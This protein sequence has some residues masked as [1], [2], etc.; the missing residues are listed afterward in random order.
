M[1]QGR[2]Q[3][4]QQHVIWD[5]TQHAWR[6]ASGRPILSAENGFTK[7]KCVLGHLGKPC[8]AASAV[9]L[10][11]GDRVPCVRLSPPC[12]AGP[13]WEKVGVSTLAVRIQCLAARPGTLPAPCC[14]SFPEVSGERQVSG[15][16]TPP[17]QGVWDTD[18]PAQHTACPLRL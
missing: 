8:E 7:G 4:G 6:L 16:P 1:S 12:S 10:E 11:D 13:W 5:Q 14:A 17:A 18:T 15:I 2:R 9:G 3:A